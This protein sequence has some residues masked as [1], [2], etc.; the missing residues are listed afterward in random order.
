MA[1]C[2]TSQKTILELLKIPPKKSIIANQIY[3]QESKNALRKLLILSFIY[4]KR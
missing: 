2:K 1:Y 3:L 4:V